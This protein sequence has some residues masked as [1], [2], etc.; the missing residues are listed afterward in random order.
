VDGLP[1]PQSAR[2]E[3]EARLVCTPVV[4]GDGGPDRH[5]PA[6]PEDSS[7]GGQP[8]KKQGAGDV[9]VAIP[10]P[11][12]RPVSDAH[13]VTVDDGIERMEVAVTQN[14]IDALESSS[15]ADN[16]LERSGQIGVVDVL[17]GEDDESESPVEQR[18]L[19]ALWKVGNRELMEPRLCDSQEV[20]KGIR[21]PG[22]PRNARQHRGPGKSLRD[23]HGPFE[24]L[25]GR[26]D[27]QHTGRRE[28]MGGTPP[29]DLGL[30]LGEERPVWTELQPGDQRLLPLLGKVGAIE[31]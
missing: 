12:V 21:P 14:L 25:A 8:E 11:R 30:P 2:I 3:W 28:V 19:D 16:A 4:A 17:D 29:L 6:P 22:G 13:L 20:E 27:R 26:H 10:K 31:A 15:H 1:E 9:T 7:D 24:G 18:T 23:L 5:E